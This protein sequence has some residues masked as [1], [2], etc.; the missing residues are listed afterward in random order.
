MV[1]SSALQDGPPLVRGA[2]SFDEAT[3]VGGQTVTP[4]QIAADISAQLG[5]AI[6]G[7]RG[8]AVARALSTNDGSGGNV[9][10]RGARSVGRGIRRLFGGGSSPAAKK[11]ASR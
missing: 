3:V 7:E 1:T 10:S 2:A 11:P 4:E 8:A 9:V 6:G 5:Q